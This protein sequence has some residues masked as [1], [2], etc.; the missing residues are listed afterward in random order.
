MNCLGK[1]VVSRQSAHL[2]S[3]N[4]CRTVW[5]PSYIFICSKTWHQHFNSITLKLLIGL[6]LTALHADEIQPV[7][8][9]CGERHHLRPSFVDKWLEKLEFAGS[10]A[11]RSASAVFNSSHRRHDS[12]EQAAT[13]ILDA[14]MIVMMLGENVSVA[15]R[16]SVANAG[17]MAL[18]A[19]SHGTLSAPNRTSRWILF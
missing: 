16:A 10:H 13:F 12:P 19:K 1:L 4:G 3:S 9:V 5:D 6:F 8:F 15:F 2:N 11:A 14:G 7:T 18:A 17:A